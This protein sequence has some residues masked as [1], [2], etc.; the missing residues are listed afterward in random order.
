VCSALKVSRDCPSSDVCNAQ[1]TD[2]SIYYN[3]NKDVYY[4]TIFADIVIP[5][6]L[7]LYIFLKMFIFHFKI[8]SGALDEHSLPYWGGNHSEL[9][10]AVGLRYALNGLMY[11][12]TKILYDIN[13]GRGR[14]NC[15]IATSRPGMQTSR[16]NGL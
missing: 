11:T 5:A 12:Y 7:V 2:C 9:Q 16:L 10:I 3:A 1:A 15:G 8:Q 13:G 4:F 6:R 14:R